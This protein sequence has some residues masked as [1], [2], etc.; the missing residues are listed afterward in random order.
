MRHCS[1]MV[2]P[3]DPFAQ[4]NLSVKGAR[5]LA[6][7]RQSNCM[8]NRLCQCGCN[9]PHN[10]SVSRVAQDDGIRRIVWYRHIDHRNRHVGLSR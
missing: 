3:V 7:R 8:D 4:F 1:E 10:F 6:Q 5:L 2:W 9:L